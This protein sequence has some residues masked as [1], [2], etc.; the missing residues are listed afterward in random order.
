MKTIDHRELLT[1]RD[2]G[3][4]IIETLPALEYN[5]THIAGAIHMP[6][7]DVMRKAAA[8]IDRERPA[9]TYCRDTL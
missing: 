8:I 6:L 7:R 5:A 2:R 4:Q 9:V 1:L 3:A